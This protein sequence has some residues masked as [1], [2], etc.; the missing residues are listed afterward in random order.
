MQT[1]YY[2]SAAGMVTQFNRLD[3]IANNLANVNTNGYKED[4]LI[5]GDFMRLYQQ[6]RDELPNENNTKEAAKFLNR[7]M[8]K[9]PQVVDEYTNFSVGNLQKTSNPLDVALSR[10]NLF[11]AVKTPEGV[12]LTRD[13]SFSL[14]DEGKL[15]T[16]Q[17]YEVLGDDY[18]KSKEGI[19]FSTVDSVIDIDKNGQIYTNVPGS[20]TL[21][22]N[23]KLFIA[24]VDNLRYL[25]KEG[26]NLYRLDDMKRLEIS[27]E[28]GAVNQGFLEKS[29][30]NA[31]KMMTQ[32]IETNRLVGMYQ[33]A[34]DTQMNE[35]NR[36]AIE[37]IAKK[38]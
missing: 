15:V 25:K 31:V 11:F 32:L 4:N 17:G 28:S 27:E 20:V 19:S 22:Q 12:R 35:M 8:T 26:D 3:T 14:D 13:G 6:K 34:M 1:G 24:N 2:S 16:K 7:T 21:T 30:V 5:I 38:V 36:D 9:A 18:F 33:K 29:N 23:K 37:K 10:E